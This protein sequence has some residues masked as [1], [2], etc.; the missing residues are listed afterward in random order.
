MT[1]I[2]QQKE[3]IE[4][5]LEKPI[6]GTTTPAPFT[7]EYKSQTGLFAGKFKGN[8]ELP[9]QIPTPTEPTPPAPEEPLPPIP[10]PYDNQVAEL[11]AISIQN[12]A[13]QIQN[14]NAIIKNQILDR[15]SYERSNA[16]GNDSL[17]YDW[18]E[19]TIDPAYQVTFTVLVPEGKVLFLQYF[20][21]TYNE[22][23][24]YTH[25][26][27]SVTA[28]TLPDLTE[29]LEDFGDH[30]VPFFN[31]PHLCYSNVVFSVANLGI[32]PRT[33]G[34]FVRGF[35]RDTTKINKGYVGQR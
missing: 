35:F 9:K 11:L 18:A 7:G 10:P 25:Q 5:F 33:Y 14:E 4:E 21:L 2:P 6:E 28:P 16:V 8:V 32:F 12:Q 15:I 13:I 34:I 1:T 22:D 19:E 29:P 20:N 31:P 3:K 17:L 23:S 24:Y 30:G 27:D 26:L